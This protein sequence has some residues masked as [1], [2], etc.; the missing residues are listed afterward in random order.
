M[1]QDGLS[2]LAGEKVT[3]T[4]TSSGT[5]NVMSA[6]FAIYKNDGTNMADG[7][8]F[9]RYAAPGAE[10]NLTGTVTMPADDNRFVVYAWS[11]V[12]GGAVHATVTCVGKSDQ[13]ITF[14]NPG[15]LN[16]GTTPTLTASASSGLSP[17]FTSAT[18]GVCTITN[19]GA[20]TFATTGICTINTN[21]AGNASYNAAPQVQ[22]SFTINPAVPVA[23][24]VSATVNANSSVNP[25]TL[26]LSG[27]TATSVAVAGAP[28]HGTAT[29]SGMT[30]SYTPTSGYAGSDSFTYT[31]TN[32]GGTSS[33]ATVT[34]TVASPTVVVLPN[35]ALSAGTVNAAYSQTLTASGGTTPY[36]FSAAGSL[37]T[38]L[39]LSPTGILSGTPTTAGSFNFQVTATDSSTGLNAPFAGSR[40]YT[41]TI[42]GIAPIAGA[43]SSTVSANSSANPITLNLSG[44]TAESVA[45]VTA[46]SHGTASASGL[47]ITYTPTIGYSG[48]DSFTYTA[49]N[50]NGTSS[51]ATVTV[52]VSPPT[53]A[54]SPAAG[55]LPD[56][57]AGTAYSQTMTASLGTAPYT[58]GLAVL[59][60][61]LPTGLS[62]DTTTSALSGIP[63]TIGT[64]S[65]TVSATDAHGATGSATYSLTT[66]SGLQVPSTSNVSTTVDANSA[67]N[68]ITLALSGGTADSV[69]VA[70]APAHGTASASGITITY[71]PTSGYSGPDSFTYTATNTA[72][73]SST[74]T[75]TITV[76]ALP[77]LSI[78]DVSHSEA[79]SGTTNFTFTIS[80]DK[81]AGAGGVTFD[82]A[83]A[84]ATA[85]ANDDYTSNSLTGQTISAGM[86][87][88]TFTVAVKGDTAFEANETFVVN[89]T[90]VSGATVLGSQ[91]VGTI[92][93]DDKAVPTVALSASGGTP[94]LG[95]PVTF[96]ATLAGGTSP[97]G[98]VTFKD[99]STTL[100][101]GTISGTTA[102]F[103]TAALA[104]G[105]HSVTAEYAGD[106]DNA[107]ATSAAVAVNVGQLA[108]T[109]ALSASDGTPTLGAPVTFTATLAGGTSPTG[110]VTFKDGSTTLGTGTI[111]GT[112]ATFSTAALAVGAHSVTAEYA[113][114]TNNA[115]ATSA[116]VAVNV[117][118]LAPTVA[119]SASDGTPTLG[120]PVTFTA[121]LAG[122]TSPTG[123]VTF[124][125]GSTTLGTGTISGTTATF[126]TAALAVGA[127]S[128]TAEYAGDT[129]N[130]AATSAAVAVN[131]G[132][133]APTV[134]L[135]ASD[136][137]PTLGAPVTFTATLAG[138]TSPTGTVTF[139]DGSTTLGTGTISGTT[140]TFSTAALAVGA[141]SVTAE[142]AGDTNNAAATSAAV[143]VN[144]GQLAPTVALSASD[145]TPTL[146]APVTFTATLAGGTS[147]TGTVTFKDGSTTL[148]TGTISGT[149]ATFST[150]ALAV[151]AHSVTAEYAGDTN[152]AAATSAAVAVNVGQLAPTVALSASDGTPTLGAPVTFTATLAGGTSPTGTVTFKDGSTTLGTGTISG[153]TATFSTAALAVG[154]HSVT[155]EYAGDTNNAAA[156]SAAVAVN[157][158]Q[159]APTVALSASDGTPTLG[160]P[161]TFTATLAGGTSPTGTVT[162]KDGSTTLGTGT[163]SGTTAT[164]STAA[165][166]V[167]AHSVTA[168]YAGDTNNAAATSAAVAV[169]V[170][171]LAPTVALSASDGTPTLGAPVTFTATLA[172]GTSPTGTVTFKD[173]STTLGTGTISGTTATFSTAA[174]AVG[175][176]SVT[177]EYA[178]DTNNAAATSAAVA[179]NV[180]QLAP[181]VALS[182]S[183]GTPTLGAPVTFTA[184]LAGGTSP[185]GTVTFKDGSTTLGTGTI[186]GTTATF[187]TA[188][189]AVG[190]HSVTAEYAGDTDNAAATSAAVAVNVG[191]LAPTVALS[192]SDGTPTLGAPVTFT[193]TLAGG[194]S[195]TGTVTFKDGSTTLGTGTISGTTATFSTAALA[196][197]AH[198]VTAEYAGDTNNA[199]ATSAAVAV[200]VAA[201][202]ITFSPAGGALTEGMVGEAYSQIISA[203]GGKG[204]LTFSLKSGAMPA[205]VILNISTGALTGPLDAAVE[206]KD[207]NFTI[208]ARDG[209]GAAG[210]AS[211][212]LTV[213]P[214]AVTVTDKIIDVPAGGTPKNV[215]LEAGATGGPFTNAEPTFVEPS[216]AGTASIVRG[217]FAAAGSTPLGWYLKFVPNPAF[218]GTVQVGFKLT[219][220]LG[221]SNIGHVIYKLGYDSEKVA[222]N[223]DDLVHGF[224]Q[225]RQG[226][227]ASSIR[228][229]GL[230]ERRQLENAVDPVTARMT[231]S[232][233]GMRASFSTSLIQ[234]EAARNSVDGVADGYASPFNVWI[235][236]TLMVHE[237]DE[238]DGKWGSFAMINLGADY[239]ISEKALVGLSV[240]F[241]RMTD[242]TKED[243]ELTGNG[244]L[245]GPY[246]SLEITKG[247]YWDTSLLY[248]G[249]ANDIDT[250]FWD[251]SFDTKRWM[252]DTA[253][254][255]EWQIDEV[256]ALTPKLRAVY[257]NE[258]VE[259]YKVSNGAGDDLVMEGFDAEQFRVS[260]GAEVARSFTLEN[261]SVV[262]PKFGVT[263]GYAGLDGSGVY[264]ALTAGL[265]LETANFWMLDASLLL[266]I[267]GDGQKSVGGRVRAG[268]LF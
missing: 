43:V 139:K 138:G 205:G 262:T 57:T 132:Q 143:A 77:S 90:N 108:P 48:S 190:A 99:G 82:V 91:G 219:S 218:S 133:L 252:F 3:Y 5:L 201:S 137:T 89:V 8:S 212:S 180:G 68:T 115:A 129:N 19:S 32:I 53:L 87:S 11:D 140:A 64:V 223:I 52:G 105:A 109:V 30:I 40:S 186:S 25:I 171:Q 247:V 26:N 29:A 71:T 69:A 38:G 233:D 246:A 117:G 195:P 155:A 213:K 24:A 204:A 146:G 154:A 182:A 244:W 119:L 189:L 66:V 17:V 126:S 228:V 225:T 37:P 44:G 62:F 211:Y 166:A 159:L 114:D 160:A 13:T 59:S 240:H 110:T 2:V 197:G 179:V 47:S 192:A 243:A 239:L 16:F 101:T 158:G 253:I 174:L 183:D 235:D 268:K 4:A 238:N 217:E 81:P 54:L 63:T 170:G 1:W 236:G 130:A 198:S 176:H 7:I 118:Q 267:E 85:S 214:R 102:T 227:I 229:P 231:P 93:N 164:F 161:V 136:G 188:A 248:G 199:A 73:T 147:P 221:A 255:G 127:H 148:G 191:Q 266:D 234:M 226:L 135:S 88:A 256:T 200:N 65:F 39:T 97:T 104:V 259:D 60:G 10:L 150:A 242:P 220:A 260:L 178:G 95:A 42:A 250:T 96:T 67:S 210:S 169:N 113:G 156:T 86:T 35:G 261:G 76:S 20:L 75:V 28:S 22:Q 61:A 232:E 167:G 78:N 251:G 257:L 124:K 45:V 98:T 149:T 36:T 177:A 194:T 121:T 103:S 94:T 168:E 120:A 27:G 79:D 72:G 31:A 23:A 207:Y 141:H 6:G 172:G 144:V 215:N 51:V 83:T 206:A 58:Y 173:G 202:V 33:P 263:A 216:S 224:V 46:A 175:A 116:A 152:N 265:T 209:F 185:T 41:V 21:Q 84:D 92:V 165:L 125:D 142:Y 264:G 112:T 49:T 145:G 70:A 181:T 123:T 163:I 74:A 254:K 134:A 151:G 237:R 107:A 55:V 14:N 131:V 100:G 230:L 245:A 80:L 56:G 249:S 18:T 162:F 128:V 153:T 15:A 241:D 196:V 193:A 34:I 208:E 187:S 184:T 157:V 50:T 203:T 122:G 9:E 111:S 12:A 222:E 106:T 258:T